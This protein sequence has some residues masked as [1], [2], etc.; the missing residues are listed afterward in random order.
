MPRLEFW[1]KCVAFASP[2][3]MVPTSTL[4]NDAAA[5]CEKLLKPVHDGTGPNWQC[6]QHSFEA[7]A[8]MLLSFNLVN[9]LHLSSSEL[10]E[11]SA[12]VPSFQ[13]TSS[14][15]DASLGLRVLGVGMNAD[16]AD[17]SRRAELKRLRAE[18]AA[19]E[20][21]KM[22][23]EL[24]NLK[25]RNK[26]M[27]G[28]A[29]ETETE[30]REA[31]RQQPSRASVRVPGAVWPEREGKFHRFVA[32][33][34]P[35]FVDEG[36][37]RKSRSIYLGS[38]EEGVY[39]GSFR[40][41]FTLPGK[42]NETQILELLPTSADNPSFGAV[43]VSVQNLLNMQLVKGS[44][45]LPIPGNVTSSHIVVQE[46]RE[47]FIE[48]KVP[49]TGKSVENLIDGMLD[50][51]NKDDPMGADI[52]RTEK[53]MLLSELNALTDIGG[54]MEG[55]IIRAMSL[56]AQDGEMVEYMDYMRELKSNPPWWIQIWPGDVFAG[57][58]DLE[59]GLVILDG[60]GIEVMEYFVEEAAIGKDIFSDEEVEIVMIIER[61]NPSSNA[62]SD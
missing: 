50:F 45:A 29:A 18:K 62:T 40:V 16:S 17:A 28:N 38:R 36:F 59:E 48:S 55:D 49:F 10:L 19:L 33:D 13:S 1:M 9:S 39:E 52:S 11:A 32:K 43:K 21:Q 57:V 24:E 20:I 46:L 8:K 26:E 51:L 37:L 12:E 56:P 6:T 3:C 35:S 58:P 2:V 5:Q 47:D 54:I 61:P 15:K 23:L 7:L 14:K 60:K 22:K 30:S 4:Q 27:I 44:A 34:D 31:L 53:E 41:R 42:E 25:L